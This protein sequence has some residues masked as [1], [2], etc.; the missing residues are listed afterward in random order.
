M[1]QSIC[2]AVI[3]VLCLTVLG[4]WANPPETVTIH[5][6]LLDSGGQALTGA[7]DY[8]VRFYDAPGGG[9]QLGGDLTGSTSL[10]AEGLFNVSVTLPAEVLSSVTGAW[11]DIAVD[12][13][14]VPNGV[15]VID[16][17]PGRVKVE[18]VPFALQT[19]EA[20]HVEAP[21]VGSGN[22]DN[23]EFDALN[24]VSSG[25]QGQL[26]AKANDVDV[27]TSQAAQDTV[28][29]G[30]ANS[31]DVYLKTQTYAK[32]ETYS[33]TEANTLLLEK[34]GY[35]GESY[36]IVKTTNNA[37]TN[38]ANLLAAYATAKALTPCG[39]PL[40]TTNRAAVLVPPGQYNL[41]TG[42]LTM[43]TEFVD[44]VGLSTAR[45]DQHIY[46]IS[47]GA[48]TGVLRQTANDVRIEN[49]FVECKRASGTLL[50]NATDPA[51]YFPDA[52]KTATV[53]RNCHFQQS[54]Y[55][56]S[57]RTSI[58]YAGTYEDCR[59]YRSSFGGFSGGLASGTF[60]DCKGGTGAF[61][62]TGGATSGTFFNCK[63][64]QESFGGDGGTAGGTFTDC[65]GGDFTF[66]AYGTASGT[67][68]NCT[69]GDYTFGDGGT[70]GG[71]FTNCTGGVYA[72]GGDGTASGTFTDCTGGN[73]AF[74]GDGVASGTFF[75]CVGG[76][77]SFGDYGTASGTFTDC[78]GGTYAFAS[79]G[80][81]SGT[82]TGCT[83]GN[84][85][86]GGDGGDTTNGKFHGCIM[87]GSYW[88]GTFKGRM[89]DCRWNVGFTC[90]ATARIYRSTILGNVNLN[91]TAAGIAQCTVKGNINNAVNAVFNTANVTS[92]DVN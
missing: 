57:M 24:G 6:Q 79:K 29:G 32:T 54:N 74:G 71:T 64:D 48:N 23:T 10:S 73:G 84:G 16:E 51:A 13:D 15:G 38:G 5:G 82:F 40:S 92:P 12:S 53:V 19:Q 91:S 1:K 4:A 26:N 76:A 85:A 39:Q 75:R 59:G 37:T 50:A 8:R 63:A 66:G 21:A 31:A 60:K 33:Q 11:Y 65:T 88:A 34:L 3:V 67:F 7:R 14:A 87:T 20:L 44:L 70:A 17:F 22:V 90:D 49:L 61:G 47:N 69:G 89:E 41:G 27:D 25:I 80:T 72:F 2:M 28:I 68:T 56:R 78:T 55:A 52:A 45:D 36:V 86:F 30:K 42:Q 43:N 77:S 9:A 83:G 46:G 81:A 18:S 58:E 35:T 62:G